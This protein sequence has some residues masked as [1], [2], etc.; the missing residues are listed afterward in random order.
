MSDLEGKRILVTGGASGIGGATCRRLG[1]KG[2]E[3]IVADRDESGARAVAEEIGGDALIVDFADLDAA[4]ATV[5]ESCGTL[6]GLVNGAA[7]V[8]RTEFPE[9]EAAD[10]DRVID[11][12][13][14]APFRLTQAL[15][16][17]FDPAGAAVVNITSIASLTVLASTGRISP[18]YSA[19]KAGLRMVS[20]SL[21]AVLGRRGIRVNAVAPGFIETPMTSEE[22]TEAREWLSA[23]IPLG[24]WGKPEELAGPITFLLG[25]DASY[26]N[27]TTLVVDGG[28][29]I[30]ILRGL[31]D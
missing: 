11:L 30:G 21:A 4:I 18:A 8:P 16:D 24:R 17:R 1:S 2:A 15:L 6:Q 25:D 12:D 10:W 3:V 27:G 7:V 9:V 31:N 5:S 22:Q 29:T 13:L 28:L 19:A 23:R 14:T 20:D 26:V